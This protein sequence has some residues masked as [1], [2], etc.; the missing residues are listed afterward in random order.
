MIN[1]YHYKQYNNNN[2]IVVSR[3]DRA[4]DRKSLTRAATLSDAHTVLCRRKS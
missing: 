2:I 3:T 1:N 4:R